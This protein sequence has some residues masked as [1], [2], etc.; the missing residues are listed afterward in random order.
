MQATRQSH[1]KVTRQRPERGRLLWLSTDFCA[2]DTEATMSFGQVT[3]LIW[4]EISSIRGPSLESR[5]LW[6][7]KTACATVAKPFLP[8]FGFREG[9]W[10]GWDSAWG[11]A[12]LGATLAS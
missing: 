4:P 5:H 2:A 12:G 6:G 7:G 11:L 10:L 9:V 3:R 8:G 1:D